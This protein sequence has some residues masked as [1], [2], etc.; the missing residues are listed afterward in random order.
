MSP[1][2]G[3]EPKIGSN[4][5]LSEIELP[6][7]SI[8]VIATPHQATHSKNG[9]VARQLHKN[10]DFYMGPWF[11]EVFS[12]PEH[13]LNSIQTWDFECSMNMWQLRQL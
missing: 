10:S 6:Y 7:C 13:A 9:S 8:V 4:E 11:L 2:R 3:K 5:A 12:G 1:G